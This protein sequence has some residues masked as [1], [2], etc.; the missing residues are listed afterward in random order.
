MEAIRTHRRDGRHQPVIVGDLPVRSW[1]E[2]FIGEAARLQLGRPGVSLA[3]GDAVYKFMFKK[4]DGG[5]V[6]MTY[7]QSDADLDVHPMPRKL[8]APYVRFVLAT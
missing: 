1:G 2:H 7:R 6:A 5:G 8:G 3:S 4:M